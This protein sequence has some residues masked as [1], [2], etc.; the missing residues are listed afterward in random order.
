MR[1]LARIVFF[2][3][4]GAAVLYGAYLLVFPQ[5]THRFRITITVDDNG[6]PRVGSG[7]VTVTYQN[8]DALLVNQKSWNVS[9]RGPAPWVDLGQ[10]GIIAAAI[11]SYTPVNYEPMPYSAADLSFVAYYGAKHHDPKLSKANIE[12]ISREAGLRKLRLDQMPEFIWIPDVA[13][14]N[15]AELVPAD[16]FSEIIGP[17]IQLSSVTVEITDA[18]SDNSL[19]Q[20]LP[21]LSGMERDQYRRLVVSSIPFKLNATYLVG[22]L[23]PF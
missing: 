1:G 13:N 18:G 4:V 23:H 7:V 6:K 11:Y 2:G 22:D 15:S 8:V 3:A 14:P 12:N 10:K 9:A 21:W 17:G 19:Y 20:K 16:K 5:Y